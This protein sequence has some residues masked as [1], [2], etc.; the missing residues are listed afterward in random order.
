[1][2]I[3]DSTQVKEKGFVEVEPSHHP[4]FIKK[5][6]ET[7]KGS[8]ISQHKKES[9]I[10]IIE[11]NKIIR[12]RK[13]NHLLNTTIGAGKREDTCEGVGHKDEEIGGEEGLLA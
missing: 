10:D 8:R 9:V 11:T 12:L 1:M 4:K 3:R 5:K 7:G 2:C 13:R 6:L